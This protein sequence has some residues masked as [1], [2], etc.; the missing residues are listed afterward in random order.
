M[1]VFYK[2]TA[3]FSRVLPHR[4]AIFLTERLADGAYFISH[5]KARQI[6]IRNLGQVFPERGGRELANTCLKTFRNFGRFIYEFLLLPKL[7]SRSMNAWLT[8][9]HEEIVEEGLRRKRGVIVLTGHLGNWELG[10]AFLAL[11]GHPLTV[12]AM[13]HPSEAV[14]DFFV[15]RRLV[16]RMRVV[17]LKEAVREC[18]R[19]L[20]G[21][22]VVALLGDRD[23]TGTGEVVQFFGKNTRVPSGALSLAANTRSLVVPAFAVRE[24]E[25]YK[26]HFNAP[27]E[28]QRTE[29]R[30]ED[31]RVNLRRWVK[32]L[33]EYIRRYPDQW[34]VFAPI[35]STDEGRP[36]HPSLQ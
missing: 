12:V 11:S 20:K 16:H 4:V 36:S 31:L 33:E 13:E 24:G 7:D 30:Q 10:A 15:R 18:L 27:L 8:P 14:T 1:I 32:I 6:V 2:V 22:E 25:K 17:S 9:V 35:W 5:R 29:N 21:N 23:Y 19:A 26:V 28:L 3:F 34:F